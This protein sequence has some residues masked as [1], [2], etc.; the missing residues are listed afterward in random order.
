MLVENYDSIRSNAWNH[1]VTDSNTNILE[2]HSNKGIKYK[3]YKIHFNFKIKFN[4]DS[5][6]ILDWS[7]KKNNGDHMSGISILQGSNDYG[8]MTLDYGNMRYLWMKVYDNKGNNFWPRIEYIPIGKYLIGV[9][10][11]FTIHIN[12]NGITV[13]HMSNIDVVETVSSGLDACGFVF[14]NIE[15][16]PSLD[17]DYGTIDL[18][19]LKLMTDE[20]IECPSLTISL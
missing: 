5:N 14:A 10:V 9:W 13:Y 7:H 19:S 4:V 18:I 20:Y 1:L 12:E 15:E 11:Q 17:V 16:R 6:Y 2:I 8:D 3:S